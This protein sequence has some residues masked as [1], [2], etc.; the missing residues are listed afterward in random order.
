MT[1]LAWL[2]RKDLVSECRSWQVWPEMLHLGLLVAVL[3][4]L[5]IELPGEY[6]RRVAGTLFWFAVL[7]AGLPTLDRSFASEREDR[8]LEGLLLA[9]VRL[10][11]LYFAKLF[12]NVLVLA[13]LAALL[14]P[15]WVVLL[16]VPMLDRPSPMLAV[17]ALGVVGIAAVGTLLSALLSGLGGRRGGLAL[18]MLPLVIPL[19]LAASEATRLILQGTLTAEWSRWVQF[20]AA[21]AAVF[22]VAGSSLF[23]FAVAE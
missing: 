23:E 12:V 14:L 15:L 4:G 20:L 10:S 13:V 5:Q 19:I 7:F 22:V 11:T 3:F 21:F 8:C 9:P 1:A 6:Q 16:H 2:I 17:T 18:V